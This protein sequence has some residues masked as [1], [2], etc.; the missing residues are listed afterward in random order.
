M[1]AIQERD[2]NRRKTLNSYEK[3]RVLLKKIKLEQ[4]LPYE[5]HLLVEKSLQ[6][7]PKNSSKTRINNRCIITGRMKGRVSDFLISRLIFR[8][9]A[10]KRD[11]NG[12]NKSSW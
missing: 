7:L 11:L 1:K 6:K 12:V 5:L 4:K 2:K 8:K 10:L 3:K 9:I